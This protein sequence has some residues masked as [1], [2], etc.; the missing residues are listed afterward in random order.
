M[1]RSTSGYV[2]FAAHVDVGPIK[3]GSS[4]DPNS[5]IIEL[6]TGSPIWLD[7]LGVMPVENMLTAESG[8]HRRFAKS[9]SHGEWFH[10]TPEL[11]DLIESCPRKSAPDAAG[12]E[13]DGVHTLQQ[14]ATIIGCS[15]DAMRKRAQR[16][17]VAPVG[18]VGNA[19]L[20]RLSDLA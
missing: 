20:Y 10:R 17:P 12:T 5:R 2:Y 18:R 14:A 19:Y 13:L 3:I 15:L 11:L 7:L 1:P 6:R 9:R 4:A 8:L 16:G